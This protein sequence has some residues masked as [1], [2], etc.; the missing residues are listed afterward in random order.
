MP[1]I[2]PQRQS[3]VMFLFKLLARLPLPLLHGIGIV[4]GWL[5]Y[6]LPF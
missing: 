2:L 6:P 3:R 1:R 4:L 5:M